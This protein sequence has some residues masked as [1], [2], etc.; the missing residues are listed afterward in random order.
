VEARASIVID[1]PIE[2]VFAFVTDVSRMPSWVTG[3]TGSRMASDTVETGAHFV[4]VYQPGYRETEL[5]VVVG[6]HEPPRRFGFSTERGPFAFSGRLELEP[7]ESGTRVSSIIEADPDSLSTKVVNLLLGR[8]LSRS[9]VRRLER[10]LATLAGA[11]ASDP[12]V[13]S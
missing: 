12:N 1:Q 4:L 3:V 2:R 7:T 8:F 5:S 13:R 9:M 11:I 6:D 10:E